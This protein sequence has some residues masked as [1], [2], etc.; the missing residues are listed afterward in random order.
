MI[1]DI[2]GMRRRRIG[3]KNETAH[4]LK[5]DGLPDEGLGEAG[6]VA[7]GA[8]FIGIIQRAAGGEF[9]DAGVVEF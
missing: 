7:P 1:F 2:N 8:F 3:V 6:K 4:E 9:A 5:C